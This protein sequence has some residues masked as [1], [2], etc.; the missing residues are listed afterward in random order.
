M[1]KKKIDSKKEVAKR[2][3]F[4]KAKYFQALRIRENTNGSKNNKAGKTS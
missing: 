2:N 1:A 3:V 4:W